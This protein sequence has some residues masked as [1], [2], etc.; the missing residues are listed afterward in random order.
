[1]MLNFT[2]LLSGSWKIGFFSAQMIDPF[3]YPFGI[4]DA[5]YDAAPIRIC[6]S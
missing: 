6:K 4:T 1:M 2:Y 3:K 5:N